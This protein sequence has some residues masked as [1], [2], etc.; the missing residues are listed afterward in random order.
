[1]QKNI[2][3]TY[4]Y[5]LFLGNKSG[6]VS[7]C[8]LTPTD[9]LL[10][11]H[12]RFSVT[13]IF[14][15][16][17]LYL[18]RLKNEFSDGIRTE[19]EYSL[20]VA[21]LQRALKAGHYIFP[22]IHAHWLDAEYQ[23]ETHEWDLSNTRYYRFS[24]LSEYEQ[25]RVF[26]I[27]IDIIKEIAEPILPNYLIDSYRAGGWS[28]QPFEHFKRQFSK[29]N[30]KYDFSVIPGKRLVTN[31]HVYDFLAAPTKGCYPFKD[32]VN[33]ENSTGQFFEFSISSVFT[34]QFTRWCY[35]KI[36]GIK[37]RLG[38]NKAYG[39][40]NVIEVN[41]KED[42]DVIRNNRHRWVASLEGLNIISFVIYFKQIF[43]QSY[44]QF[45]SHPKIL[46]PL[47][48]MWLRI[49]FISLK[50]FKINTDFRKIV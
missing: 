48:L 28:I 36:S 42:I 6:T 2:L 29:Y 50:V 18:W 17:T 43:K 34:S 37:Q 24:S 21:Q 46:T 27:S 8:L 26:Q 4:D 16:D 10:K 44:F 5:E 12:N 30:F 7:N 19:T 13:A 32:D 25:N 23:S 38:L 1:M 9:K 35:F 41:V 39:D 47:E 22:H 45:I 20:I 49:L 15:V 31:A 11:I 14:F 3:F 33:I 40:G